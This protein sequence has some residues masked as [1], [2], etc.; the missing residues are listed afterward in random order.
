[1]C[2]ALREIMADE[3]KAAEDRGMKNT[4]SKMQQ[5]YVIV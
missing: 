4:S 5:L 2:E 3:L 1:M